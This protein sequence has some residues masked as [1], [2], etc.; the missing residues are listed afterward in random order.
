MRQV[1]EHFRVGGVSYQLRQI[2]NS[3]N[4][5]SSSMLQEKPIVGRLEGV[6]ELHLRRDRLLGSLHVDS[7]A[8]FLGVVIG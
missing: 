6:D 1:D 5:L 7:H 8:Q 2:F 4:K 3:R